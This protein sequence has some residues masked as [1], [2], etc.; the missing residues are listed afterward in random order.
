MGP[1]V[2]GDE[3]EIISIGESDELFIIETVAKALIKFEGLENGVK[4][5]KKDDRR[6]WISLEYSSSKTEGATFEAVGDDDRA[7]IAV[8]VTEILLNVF[9]QVIPLQCFLD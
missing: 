4:D 5:Q 3:A 1:L 6:D 7:S 8:E 2:S 9:W